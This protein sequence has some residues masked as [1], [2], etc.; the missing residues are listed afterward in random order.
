MWL[1]RFDRYHYYGIKPRS[2]DLQCI[3]KAPPKSSAA[4]SKAAHAAAKVCGEH[5]PAPSDEFIHDLMRLPSPDYSK[6][7]VGI[8]MEHLT[9]FL[10]VYRVHCEE[11]LREGLQGRFQ[12]F[13]TMI[14]TF[15]RDIPEFLLDVLDCR[16]TCRL[17]AEWDSTV[18]QAMLSV[19]LPDILSPGDKAML[20]ELRSFTKMLP[21][22]LASA[23]QNRPEMAFLEKSRVAH[24]FAKIVKQ[25]YILNH[26]ALAANNVMTQPDLL[27][28]MT[29]V[30]QDF[31]FQH[32][33]AQ[34]LYVCPNAVEVLKTVQE[35]VLKKLAAKDN[36]T[37][38]SEWVFEMIDT[39]MNF[40]TLNFSDYTYSAQQFVVR[41][42]YIASLILRD[43]CEKDKD[44]FGRW[45][46]F[47][48]M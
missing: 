18:F 33:L 16:E 9:E 41:W 24:D 44:I 42:H 30:W 38:W 7:P 3:I 10:R 35:T 28:K 46:K 15:W 1:I 32:V 22:I 39:Y 40:D 11:L 17:I 27:D 13:G 6:F 31:D 25:Y 5:R 45:Y 48:L 37:K 2:E 21:G 19:F 47:I 20:R 29:T 36:V 12:M 4:K 8:S 14:G 26:L 23:F 43:I 34:A